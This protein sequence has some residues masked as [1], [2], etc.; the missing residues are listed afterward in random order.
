M[1][2]VSLLVLLVIVFSSCKSKLEKIPL[3]NL[4]KHRDLQDSIF[5]NV[6]L[7]ENALFKIDS[8]VGA[9][10]A[11]EIENKNSNSNYYYCIGRVY[12]KIDYI[13]LNNFYDSLNKKSKN[14]EVLKKYRKYALEN[15]EKSFQINPSHVNS[16]NNILSL[17]MYDLNTMS[18][19]SNSKQLLMP[20]SDFQR[21]FNLVINNAIRVATIDTTV[22][23]YFKK[24]IPQASFILLDMFYFDNGYDNLKLTLETPIDEIKV[25]E[26][27][28][29]LTELVNNNNTY[30]ILNR[31]YFKSQY[32]LIKNV[33]KAAD[34]ILKNKLRYDEMSKE[35]REFA[36]NYLGTYTC[37]FSRQMG[38]WL[39]SEVSDLEIKL[40]EDY[41]FTYTLKRTIIDEY[42]GNI[43]KVEL[44]TG[45]IK[46]TI[47]EKTG[48]PAWIFEGG[49]YGRH[50]AY[51]YISD[52][53]E[54]K[55]TIRVWIPA[56]G[57]GS[58]TSRDFIKK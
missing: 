14:I 6:S 7:L 20:E 58:E 32:P 23:L 16:F 56:L 48:L 29:D 5:K 13:P 53:D 28:G 12:N 2:R 57:Y 1:N 35:E 36:N 49:D 22:D 39:I 19:L 26:I 50:G 4:Q 15:Y 55:N 9:Y 37:N 51:F 54:F 10:Q 30:D 18:I 21:L 25:C 8:L 47:R 31:S 27:M 42:N 24:K 38:R 40:N 3:D 33:S 44:F 52:H 41:N 17:F 11:L 43:P 45:L 46:S 34:L